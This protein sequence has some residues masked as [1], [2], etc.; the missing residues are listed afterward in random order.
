M[1][2]Y[3]LEGE[4]SGEEMVTID[5]VE[6]SLYDMAGNPLSSQTNNIVQLK[7]TTQPVFTLTDDQT[8][9]PFGEMKQL[10]F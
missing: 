6:N 7:D 9:N 4:V 8:D 5:I 3:P 10:S 1:S 2:N